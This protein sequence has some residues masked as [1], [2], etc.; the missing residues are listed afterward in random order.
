MLMAVL[1]LLDVD[2][3]GYNC[4]VAVAKEQACVQP[5]S[6]FDLDDD[7][8]NALCIIVP[9]EVLIGNCQCLCTSPFIFIAMMCGGDR[10]TSFITM[11]IMASSLY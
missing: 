5:S 3:H 10:K 4:G 6:S 1:Q 9:R 7:A 2:D 11:M 8:D